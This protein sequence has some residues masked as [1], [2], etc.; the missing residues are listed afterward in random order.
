MPKQKVNTL[1]RKV[2]RGLKYREITPLIGK[3]II[4][5][6]RVLIANEANKF[7]SSF[8]SHCEYSS[9][10]QEFLE[11]QIAKYGILDLRFSAPQ[12]MLDV[13]A[14]SGVAILRS[15]HFV[16]DLHDVADELEDELFVCIEQLR[17]DIDEN[18]AS[19]TFS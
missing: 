7:V 13:D 11:G 17:D 12:T 9:P 19:L 10:E 4:I 5:T 3:S 2:V 15:L 8:F 14:Q 1:F 16:D 18:N 6:D